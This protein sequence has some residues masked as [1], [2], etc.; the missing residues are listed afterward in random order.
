MKTESYFQYR[1]YND[2]PFIKE[3][4][5]EFFKK[6]QEGRKRK[7]TG[8]GNQ[9]AVRKAFKVALAGMY[10]GDAFDAHGSFVRISL[11]VNNFYGK[12][13]LSPVF[14]PELYKVLN[15]LIDKG[16]IIKVAESYF[17]PSSRSQIPRGYRLA[18]DWLNKAQEPIKLGKEI[19][20][21]TSRNQAA[22]FIELRDE[23]KRCQRLSANRQKPFS[24][25]LLKWY[26]SELSNHS[27]KIGQTELPPF[28]FSLT[29]IYSRSSYELGGRFY[30]PFQSFGSQ[31]RQHLKIDGES[32][33]EVDLSSLHPTMLYRMAGN[34]QEPD[35]YTIEGY[36]RSVVKVAMQ[37]LLNT[38]KPFPPSNSLRYFLNKAK[39]R[40]GNRS[41]PNWLGEE[42]TN[43]YCEKLAK[44]IA[45]HNQPIAQYFSQ[46]IGLKLQH[47]DS[48][49]TS[50]VLHFMKQRSPSTVVI[51]IHDSYIVKQSEL[52]TLLDALTYAQTMI[53]ELNHWELRELRVKIESINLVDPEGYESTLNEWS[54]RVGEPS[55]KEEQIKEEL[56]ALELDLAADVQDL[57]DAYDLDTGIEEE[58]E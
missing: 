51:P 28:Y 5:E 33:F 17:N 31:T 10:F 49:F 44:A 53:S 3:K 12:S 35:P 13:R 40:K 1:C 43:D 50:C 37:V 52:E 48:V 26:D 7:V 6:Y 9:Q 25:N 27:F 56:Q 54:T 20:L 4:S 22:D 18:D 11:N 34:P 30:S 42:I 36:P 41:D 24:L 29:R 19:K 16:I 58:V 46:G 21:R 39:Q 2:H 14:Q 47:K 15:W 8:K 38:T 23:K 57:E 32:V 55:I 45:S